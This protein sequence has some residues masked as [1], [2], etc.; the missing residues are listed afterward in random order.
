[1]AEK[2]SPSFDCSGTWETWVF[3]ECC[4]EAEERHPGT[5]SRASSESEGCL[6]TCFAVSHSENG[7]GVEF[8][9]FERLALGE[10]HLR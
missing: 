8:E 6:E 3:E 10:T 4:V 2:L 1:M 7:E 9:Q 5:G